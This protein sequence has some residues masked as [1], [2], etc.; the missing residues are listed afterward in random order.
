MLRPIPGRMLR[1][2]VMVEVCTG[3]DAYQRPTYGEKHVVHRVC[4][5]T[6]Q[7]T[8]K[9]TDNTT[10]APHGILFADARLSRPA[11]EWDALLQKAAASGGDVRVIINGIVFTAVQAVRV[12]DDTH[13]LHHWEIALGTR[14]G[15]GM[16]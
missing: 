7:V 4:C 9:T 2:T 14:T 1:D 12:L 15:G 10:A 6:Q 11:L 5:Q 13:R 3:I 16:S 8:K